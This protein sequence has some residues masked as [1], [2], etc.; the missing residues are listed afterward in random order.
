MIL[1]FMGTPMGSVLAN[2][3]QGDRQAAVTTERVQRQKRKKATSQIHGGALIGAKHAQR[4]LGGQA[5]R[6]RAL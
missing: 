1:F 2:A 5:L 6:L 4:S 3:T